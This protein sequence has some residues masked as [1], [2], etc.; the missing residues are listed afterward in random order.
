MPKASKAKSDTE[1][2]PAPTEEVLK[3][4]NDSAEVEAGKRKAEDE[5][6]APNDK[7]AK[8]DEESKEESETPG[9]DLN[10]TSEPEPIAAST[11]GTTIFND[12]DVLSGR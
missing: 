11:E 7:K 5:E 2:D 8:T 10:P 4:E 3:E 9:L 6:A 1:G 12:A